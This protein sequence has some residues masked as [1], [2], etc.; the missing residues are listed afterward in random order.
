MEQQ[1]TNALNNGSRQHLNHGATLVELVTSIV[2]LGI[3]C[4]FAAMMI[5]IVVQSYTNTQSHSKEYVRLQTVLMQIAKEMASAFPPSITINNTSNEVQFDRVGIAGIVDSVD[6]GWLNVVQNPGL[7][8]IQKSMQV[9]LYPNLESPRYTVLEIAWNQNRFKISGSRSN[10]PTR[11][12]AFD[13]RVQYR[14]ANG[15]LLQRVEYYDESGNGSTEGLLCDRLSGFRISRPSNNQYTV[16]I[17]TMDSSTNQKF[18]LSQ[19][20]TLN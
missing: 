2:I 20:I 9:V 8:R 5:T 3:V 4:S 19:S 11:F 13:K 10:P 17:E 15:R 18:G 14:Y 12:W 7:G 16:E 6:D 1:P